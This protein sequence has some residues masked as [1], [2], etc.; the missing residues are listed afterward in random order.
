M[1]L[2]FELNLI[3]YENMFLLKIQIYLIADD[4]NLQFIKNSI[5]LSYFNTDV[6]Y[7]KSI[8]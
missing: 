3:F 7:I 6:H 4:N 1:H 5:Y 2:Y 8:T